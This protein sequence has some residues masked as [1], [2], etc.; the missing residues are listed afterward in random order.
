MPVVESE[1][2]NGGE[3]GGERVYGVNVGG[4]RG[5]NV[6][7]PPSFLERVN[8]AQGERGERGVHGG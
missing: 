8:G 7:T 6:F 4:E 1:G 2:V 5:V 3:R